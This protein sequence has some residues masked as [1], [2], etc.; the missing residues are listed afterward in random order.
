MR[1]NLP[2]NPCTHGS[3]QLSYESAQI[4]SYLTT[5][6]LHRILLTQ[7]INSFIDSDRDIEETGGHKK[8]GPFFLVR[9]L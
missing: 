2:S 8:S 4:L 6:I 1:Q 5:E 9:F 7:Q 3:N